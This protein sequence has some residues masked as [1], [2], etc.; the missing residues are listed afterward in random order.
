MRKLQTTITAIGLALTAGMLITVPSAGYM[1]AHD[2]GLEVPSGVRRMI[3]TLQSC[4]TRTSYLV[5]I[6]DP[7]IG[8][9]ICPAFFPTKLGATSSSASQPVMST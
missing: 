8:F 9:S 7:R 3:Q 5:I 1:D 2:P 6:A 4:D